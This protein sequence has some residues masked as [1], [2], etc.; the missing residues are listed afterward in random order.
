MVVV[1]STCHTGTA[2][3][4]VHSVFFRDGS[5]RLIERKLPEV[6][7]RYYEGLAGNRN[8]DLTIDLSIEHGLLVATYWDSSDRKASPL[9]VKYQWRA[10]T[11]VVYSISSPY[12]HA[13]Q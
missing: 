5:G 11:F 10:G 2:G 4:D 8:Y 9:I 3:P 7:R 12:L 6:D 1:G 13:N